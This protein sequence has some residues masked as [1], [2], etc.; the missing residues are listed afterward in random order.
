M[1]LPFNSATTFPIAAIPRHPLNSWNESRGEHPQARPKAKSR[2]GKG[3]SSR[4]G[5]NPP[6]PNRNVRPDRTGT[7]RGRATPLQLHCSHLLPLQRLGGGPVTTATDFQL[8]SPTLPCPICGRNDKGGDCRI[9]EALVLCHRGTTFSPPALAI[10]ATTSDS[11]GQKWAYTGETSDG[12]C[13]TFTLHKPL[14]GTGRSVPTSRV[15]SK[16][17]Q[18]IK[19]ALLPD[20]A[21]NVV[22]MGDPG[23]VSG[24][25]YDYSPFHRVQRTREKQFFSHHRLSEDA[26]YE[27]GK[28]EVPWPLYNQEACIQYGPFNWALEVEGEKCCDIATSSGIVCFSQPGNKALLSSSL[29]QERYACLQGAGL[30]GVVYIMDNDAEGERKGAACLAAAAAAGLPIVALKAAD[31]WPGIAAKGSIDDLPEPLDRFETVATIEKAANAALAKQQNNLSAPDAALT[32]DLEQET[33][34]KTESLNLLVDGLVAAQSTGDTVRAAALMSQTWRLGVPSSTTESLVLQRWA[35]LRG[36]ATE[37]PTAPVTGRTIGQESSAEGLVQRLAGFLL[38]HGLHLF[39]ADAGTGKTFVS[40]AMALLL[41]NGG[42]GFLDQQEGPTKIGKV[43]FIGTDGGA[44]A[45]DTLQDYATDLADKDQW[46][47]VE[48][49]CEETGK[50]KSWSLTLYNLELLAKR[51]EQGDITA[52]FIDTINAVFQGAGISPYLGPVDQYLRLLKA[53]VCP[54][55]PLIMLGHTNRSGAGIK[56]IAGSPA[57]QEVPDALHRIERLKEP[58]EDGTHIY[59]WTCEKLRGESFRQFSYALVNG[60]LKQVEGHY[61]SNCGDKVLAAIK[62][63]KSTGEPTTPKHLAD[64]TKEAPAS[65]R[66]AL[67]RL[68]QRQLIERVGTGFKV[69]PLGEQHLASI[70][71]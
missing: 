33:L 10:G 45:F 1:N 48:F 39:I 69:T 26:P 44:G 9:S 61:Y 7:L 15:P 20:G 70:K 21:H 46:S 36:I 40:L 8:S 25:L 51:L 64:D 31:V 57:F 3:G 65:V 23:P 11:D 41:A 47:N 63:R 32:L 12:R 30:A 27:T 52:V 49:W 14:R 34:Q 67:Q 38:E 18:P 55:G 66:K 35:E 60:E 19:L 53:I 6:T 56:G 29:L 50:R 71:L 2:P 13:A 62:A 22:V 68:R 4:T 28:G 5:D 54:H 59:K 37:P 42:S 43:L 24:V 16:P 17:S 58:Q